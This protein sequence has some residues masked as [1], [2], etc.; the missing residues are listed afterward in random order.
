MQLR[1]VR[2]LE[3]LGDL[4]PMPAERH[5]VT[6]M[7]ISAHPPARDSNYQDCVAIAKAELRVGG[8]TK[9]IL[10]G[11]L[12]YH[13][14]V[15]TSAARFRA[16]SRLSTILLPAS[17]APKEIVSLQ[18]VDRIEELDLPL[19]YAIQP[20]EV[21][22][23]PYMVD[24]ARGTGSIPS[25]A[26]LPPSIATI[27]VRLRSHGGDWGAWSRQLAP[28]RIELNRLLTQ[29]D[30][31]IT[32]DEMHSFRSVNRILRKPSAQWP[33][34]QL[35]VLVAMNAQLAE[36]G[37]HLVIA[38]VPNKEQCSSL[39]LLSKPPEDG[40]VDPHR[41][42]LY[43]HLLDAGLDIL[44]LRPA[45]F[46]MQ[47]AEEQIFYEGWDHH[48]TDGGIRAIATVIANHLLDRGY[49]VLGREVFKTHAVKYS[50]PEGLTHF[51][52][53]AHRPGRYTATVVTDSDGNS[54]P[55]CAQT[56]SVLLIGDSM[57]ATPAAYG[58]DSAG[59]AAHLSLRLQ[60]VVA[61]FH[62]AAGAPQMMRHLSRRPAVLENRDICVFL[63][64]E[65]TLF[66]SVRP[67]E[68]WAEAA[69]F[70]KDR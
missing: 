13:K 21:F 54:L 43:W 47:Q 58:V 42:K 49:S 44:D 66:E 61:S 37:I 46:A 26:L 40:V 70:G 41:E 25:S 34:R 39:L 50:I 19:Y 8:S 14:R 60:R 62:V 28:A 33:E 51:D 36:K 9:E 52:A 68:D 11:L 55:T 18:T 59:V 32:V 29:A 56:N 48:P 63:F 24:S 30:G 12:M 35:Q 27:E 1:H 15:D 57:V 53:S 17:E 45:L 23:S 16:G 31:L 20:V 22:A 6:V 2:A 67:A 69:I 38:P 65:D 4:S 10:L 5:T 7:E 64:S 3:F